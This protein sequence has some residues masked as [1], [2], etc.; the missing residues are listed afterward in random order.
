MRFKEFLI[1][2]EDKFLMSKLVEKDLF[3]GNNKD[4]VREKILTEIRSKD[5]DIF[6]VKSS[7]NLIRDYNNWIE[8]YPKLADKLFNINISRTLG[9]GEV[10]LYFIFDDIYLAGGSSSID[11]VNKSG[12][13]IAEVKAVDKPTKSGKINDFKFGTQAN[14]ANVNFFS[15]IVE[16]VNSYKL[17][18]GN[19]PDGYRPDQPGEITPKMLE[20]WK[21]ID[22]TDK[23]LTKNADVKIELEMSKKGDVFTQ[24]DKKKITNIHN[25]DALPKLK[26]LSTSF[27]P[28]ITKNKITTVQQIIDR[29][30]D[31]I[32]NSKITDHPFLFLD[33]SNKKA[34]DL[35]T[36]TKESL[37]I[38]RASREYVKVSLKI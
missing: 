29:W 10:L 3:P 25:K 5:T 22:L 12:K 24:I 33:T 14:K 17:L 34:I 4:E 19:Y 8:D 16:F 31:D 15:N 27:N 38:Y 35:I 6:Y 13:P 7:K 9:P 30:K 1:E 28:T 26:K 21:S 32:V 18:T 36:I 20:N 2:K 23:N 37:D 11:L